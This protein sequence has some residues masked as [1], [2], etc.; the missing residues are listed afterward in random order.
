LGVLSVFPITLIMKKSV[1]TALLFITCT[2]IFIAAG[3]SDTAGQTIN[4]AKIDSL[5]KA[6]AA[7]NQAM[8]SLAIAQKGSVVYQQAIGYSAISGTNRTAAH[9]KTHYRIGS[10]SK[11]FTAVMIFQ[12]IEENK[13][14][15]DTKLSVFYPKIPNADSI[16]ISQML[17]HRSGLYNF[18]LDTAYQGYMLKP[19]TE[20]DMLATF[21]AQ[22]SAFEPGSKAEYSNTNFVL[23]G[24]IIENLTKKTYGEALKQQ[25]GRKLGLLDTYY[26]GKTSTAK[27]EAYS[28]QPRNGWQQMPETDMSI[29]G[30]AGA[31]VS[32]PADLVKF[33]DALFAGKLINAEHL[34]LMKTLNDGYGMG[35]FEMP[36]GT[37]KAFG[38]NGDI[39]G[40][41]SVL[42]YFPEEKMAYAYCSNGIDY[43]LK[44]LMNGVLKI[45]FNQPY[46][47]PSFKTPVLTG[48]DLD[49]YVGNYSSLRIPLKI[50]VTKDGNTLIAQA[51]GQPAFPLKPLDKDKFG[52]ALSG[53]I[54]EFRPMF[55]EFTLKQGGGIFPFTKDGQ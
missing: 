3:I 51:T 50:A 41:S 52:F 55:G 40:F 23:L 12:L 38:H 24:Y 46:T 35:M 14:Q 1:L 10:I 8:G 2:F 48:A 9:L 20:T 44:D 5:L 18:V 31:V 39:D 16:T 7:E 22:P 45:S 19:R 49:K 15:L 42:G 4:K 32:T 53:I 36:F 54:M 33:I 26:G 11:M 25:I 29:P 17:A 27:N 47:I 21:V 37:K 43:P 6:V 34:T 13:L 28:Y 30:G